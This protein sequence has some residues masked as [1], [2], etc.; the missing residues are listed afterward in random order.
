MFKS[1]VVITSFGSVPANDPRPDLM[2]WQALSI[3][4]FFPDT[5]ISKTDYDVSMNASLLNPK[6]NNDGFGGFVTN[7]EKVSNIPTHF[8]FPGLTGGND[9]IEIF[10][11][12]KIGR[13]NGLGTFYSNNSVFK[14]MYSVKFIPE[15]QGSDTNGSAAVKGKVGN[16]LTIPISI[17]ANN[18][19]SVH[20]ARVM[21]LMYQGGDQE[22]VNR[23]KLGVMNN[24]AVP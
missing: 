19:P 14:T 7:T 21:E 2:V 3:Y 18:Q 24:V 11:K 16:H 17:K 15:F 23:G 9:P 20:D 6:D 1:L 5:G 8:R 4:R 12:I 10:G 13:R 22:Q